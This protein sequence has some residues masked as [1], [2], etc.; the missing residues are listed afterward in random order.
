MTSAPAITSLHL[1]DCV[2][3]ETSHGDAMIL[4]ARGQMHIVRND[5]DIAK[6][7]ALQ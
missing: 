1:D 3:P 2:P 6:T 5:G 4:E 7:D